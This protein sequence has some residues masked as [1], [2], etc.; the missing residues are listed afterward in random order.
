MT[1][2]A[3]WQ[4]LG[5]R[6][7][8]GPLPARL[9]GPRD[10]GQRIHGPAAWAQRATI[11]LLTER[12]SVPFAPRLGTSFLTHARLHYWRI[13]LDVYQSFAVAL[14]DVLEQANTPPCRVRLSGGELKDV[15]LFFD[16]VE[17]TIDW[18]SD[19]GDVAGFDI[20]LPLQEV[21]NYD[22]TAA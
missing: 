20:R 21:V 18:R 11:L 3:V 9:H 22:V 2:L 17:I 12:G 13:P 10:G 6:L 19:A 4:G 1:D 15:R 5:R 8:V 16:R 14:P 7:A